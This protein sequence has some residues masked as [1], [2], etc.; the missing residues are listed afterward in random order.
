MLRDINR[1]VAGSGANIHAQ[2]LS[3]DPEIGYLLM[4]LDEAAA[5]AVRD[6][7]EKLPTSIRTRVI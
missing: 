5:I 3:T 2:I 1:V 7:V 4:D 6:E